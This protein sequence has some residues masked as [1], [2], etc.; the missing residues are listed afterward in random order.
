ME[1]DAALELTELV[2]LHDVPD[3]LGRP[4]L[5]LLP[6]I[7]LQTAPDVGILRGITE[8]ADRPLLDA[9]V[10]GGPPRWVLHAVM[11]VRV[12]VAAKHRIQDKRIVLF[13]GIDGP[14]IIRQT[15]ALEFRAEFANLTVS[16]N[17]NQRGSFLNVSSM[18]T[19]RLDLPHIVRMVEEEGG[20]AVDF[21]VFFVRIDEHLVFAVGSDLLHSFN[22]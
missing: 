4:E 10:R 21:S 1:G 3:F 16:G 14:V 2:S 13:P 7:P 17:V 18:D 11:V 8:L 12:A 6:Q 9:P 22:V 5:A 19:K 20:S 15:E